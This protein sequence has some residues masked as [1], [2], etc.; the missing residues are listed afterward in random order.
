M[1]KSK[2]RWSKEIAWDIL[3]TG[4]MTSKKQF[5]LADWVYAIREG[6]IEECVRVIEE[7]YEDESVRIHPQIKKGCYVSV[8]LIKMINLD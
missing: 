1:E 6:V 8:E 2:E 4:E 5:K 7:Y 3:A